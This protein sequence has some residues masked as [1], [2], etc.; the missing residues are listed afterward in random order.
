MVLGV[1]PS[2]RLPVFWGVGLPLGFRPDSVP[3]LLFF[4]EGRRP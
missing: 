1:V 4:Q 3:F 2:A